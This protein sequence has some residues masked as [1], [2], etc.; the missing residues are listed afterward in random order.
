MVNYWKPYENIREKKLIIIS[1]AQEGKIQMN[2]HKLN[3]NWITQWTQNS[4]S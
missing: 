1:S 3:S 2:N 4:F